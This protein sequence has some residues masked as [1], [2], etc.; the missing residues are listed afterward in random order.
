MT[1]VAQP[2]LPRDLGV[3][4]TIAENNR[5]DFSGLGNLPG[6]GVY[7]SVT[8]GGTVRTGGDVAVA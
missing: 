4:R 7:A 6:A 8:S 1:T 5:V 3:L 2:G